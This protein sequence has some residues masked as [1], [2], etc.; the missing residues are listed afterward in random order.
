MPI[1][2]RDF[3][4]RSTADLTKV[5][6][7]RYAADSTTEV[8]CVAYAIDDGEVK[9]WIPGDPIPAESQ[10]AARS[11]EWLI[12]AHNDGFETAIEELILAPQFGWPLVP[13]ERHRCTEAQARAN[14]LP[15]ALDKAAAAVG[16]RYRK[17]AAGDKIMRKLSKS[18]GPIDPKEFARLRAYCKQDVEVERALSRRVPPLSPSEQAFWQLDAVINRRGFYVDRALAEAAHRAEGRAQDNIKTQITVLTGGKITSIHQRD[19]ILAAMRERGIDA[20]KLTKPAVAALLA[21]NDLP[22]EIHRILELRRDGAHSAAKKLKGLLAGLGSDNR[23]RNT[24]IFHGAATG[25]WSGKGFQPQNL[26]KVKSDPTA[27]IDSIMAGEGVPLL[28]IGDTLRSMICAAPGYMLIGGDFS[29]I[30]ARVLAWLANEEWVLETYH[31]FD[32][33]GNPAFEPYCVDASKVLGR[34]VSP[35]DESDRNL[36]KVLTLA[37]GYGGGLGAWRKFD[38]SDTYSDA[39]VERFK[40]EWRQ[41]HRA[42]KQFWGDL[43]CAALRAVHTCERIP[44]GNR[45]SFTMDD[46]TLCM[47]L[48]TGRAISYPQARFGPGKFEGTREIYFMD[49]AKGAWAEI[50]S[51]SGL[52]V[53]NAVQAISRDLLAAAMLRLEAAG[54]PVVLHVHDEVVCEIPEDSGSSDEFLRLLTM[55][56]AWA[57]G[58]PIAAKVWPGPRYTKTTTTRAE[59]FS[60]RATSS[61]LANHFFTLGNFRTMRSIAASSPPGD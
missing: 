34:A 55:L 50:A 7:W 3:E 48:P 41:A 13:L 52:L 18:R 2:H 27:A 28:V 26:K 6:A 12:T 20:K 38:P 24:L 9:I 49:N 8:L 15:A 53:E 21:Q 33:T 23:L 40:Q 45:F 32:E 4:T 14:A 47:R 17:D 29:A 22:D 60:W 10:E 31:K 42:T 11:A 57:D 58:L 30:E 59:R 39:D 1:L 51:W 54:Y 56:P 5:G 19:R 16:L 37:F 46:G 35:E 25:R 36:G 44:L 61:A 43:R